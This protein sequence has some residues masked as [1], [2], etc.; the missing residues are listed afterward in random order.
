[1]SPLT[2]PDGFTKLTP[3]EKIIIVDGIMSSIDQYYGNKKPTE[4]Q[5]K[6]VWDKIKKSKIICIKD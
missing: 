4:E 3:T 5:M 1:M 2:C 6:T